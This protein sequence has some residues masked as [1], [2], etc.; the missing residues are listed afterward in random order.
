MP[1]GIHIPCPRCLAANR[2]PPSR[3]ADKPVCGRCKA[4]LLSA[5]PIA[6]DDASFAA[7]VERADVPVVVDFWAAWCGPC[8]VMA[9]HFAA[10]AKTSAG[11]ALFAKV[12]TDA[13]KQTAARFAIRS[14]P[15]L[16]AF[17]HGREI[18]RQ[19]GAMSEAMIQRW[20]TTL[21]R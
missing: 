15:T 7:Y 3:L 6:L 9:P 4:P 18:A 14:I 17:D 2:V 12:D 13:A 16:I 10:A 19:S 8:T 20:V 1:D 11:R 21:P 5:H